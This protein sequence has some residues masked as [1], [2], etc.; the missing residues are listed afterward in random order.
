VAYNVSLEFRL[1]D[2][3]LATYKWE[4][5]SFFPLDGRG[6]GKKEVCICLVLQPAHAPTNSQNR[7]T[8]LLIIP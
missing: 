2:P 1:D 6:F 3:V 7:V 4:K 5:N 8:K